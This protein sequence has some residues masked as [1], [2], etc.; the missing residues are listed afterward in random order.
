M[1]RSP[2]RRRT[3]PCPVNVNRKRTKRSRNMRYGSPLNHHITHSVRSIEMEKNVAVVV[4]P[5]LNAKMDA[6]CTLTRNIPTGRRRRRFVMSG[7][8]S[9]CFWG[10]RR[11]TARRRTAHTARCPSSWMCLSSLLSTPHGERPTTVD[12]PNDDRPVT[13][14][15]RGRLN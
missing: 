4:A 9:S 13:T 5:F 8:A 2:M 3:L 1:L 15:R 6:C 14:R 11:P 12:D 7:D 10:G